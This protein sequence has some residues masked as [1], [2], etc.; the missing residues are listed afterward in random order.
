MHFKNVEFKILKKLK[1]FLQIAQ[2]LYRSSS[3]WVVATRY[4][5]LSFG[6]R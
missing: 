1:K 4:R 2:S 6:L 5:A 3:V